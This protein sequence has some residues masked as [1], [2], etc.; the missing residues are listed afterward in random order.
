MHP[1]SQPAQPPQ[2]GG[3]VRG[4][5]HHAILTGK[6]IVTTCVT[7]V[8]TRKPKST[9]TCYLPFATYADTM[10]RSG[11]TAEDVDTVSDRL[12]DAVMRYY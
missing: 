11:F 4:R 10:L 5:G 2:T 1:A 9:V 12:V 3:C 8:T 6:N 7:A